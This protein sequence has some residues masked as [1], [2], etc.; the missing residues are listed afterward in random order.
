MSSGIF[1]FVADTVMAFTQN[2][3]LVQISECLM[4]QGAGVNNAGN[5]RMLVRQLDDTR[6]TPG[7][8]YEPFLL[9]P[10]QLAVGSPS[11]DRMRFREPALTL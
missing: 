8:V 6:V 4:S 10:A 1:K 3:K 11:K 2:E 5:G 9:L 7:W